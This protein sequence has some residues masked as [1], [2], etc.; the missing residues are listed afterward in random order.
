MNK[1]Y[2]SFLRGLALAMGVALIVLAIISNLDVRIGFILTGVGL[3]AL[4]MDRFV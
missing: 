3:L 1:T 4:A 2:S